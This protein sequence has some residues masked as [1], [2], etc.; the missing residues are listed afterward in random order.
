M[1]FKVK[2]KLDELRGTPNILRN[3]EVGEKTGK[4]G[5]RGQEAGIPCFYTICPSIRNGLVILLVRIAGRIRLISDSEEGNW[6]S[7]GGKADICVYSSGSPD[8]H[9]CAAP[10]VA[11]DQ[12]QTAGVGTP[13]QSDQLSS[14]RYPSIH[15]W[16][17]S[18]RG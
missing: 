10:L 12:L 2:Y 3:Q 15:V 11:P 1:R 7:R 18:R 8:I 5:T 13:L 6:V 9:G 14:R 4:G 16:S 17:T